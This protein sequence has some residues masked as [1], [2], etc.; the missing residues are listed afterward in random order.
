MRR[1][2]SLNASWYAASSSI[3]CSSTS[4]AF[5]CAVV[6][7]FIL[8]PCVLFCDSGDVI[9]FSDYKLVGADSVLQLIVG[10]RNSKAFVDVCN[11]EHCVLIYCNEAFKCC[12]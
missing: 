1:L 3:L 7:L 2:S 10:F 4:A 11:R 12:F 9:F 5:S 6:Y 8:W